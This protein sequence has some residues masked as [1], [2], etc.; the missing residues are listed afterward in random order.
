MSITLSIATMNWALRQR[1]S[2]AHQQILL[3]VIAD[4]ADPNGITRHCDPAYLEEHSRMT[5]ATMFRR[6]GEL[7]ELGLLQR[8][9]FYSERGAPIYEIRL[10]LDAV[11]DIPIKRRKNP[12]D[13][14]HD[15]DQDTAPESH[16]ETLGQSQ[17]ETLPPT[18]VSPSAAPESQYCDSISP[19]VSKNL[20][21]PPPGALL[22]KGETEQSEK[23]TALWDRFAQSY[24]GIA[25]MDQQA[26]KAELDELSLDDA[27]WAVSVLPALKD[28]L[29]KAKDRPPKNAHIWLRKAMFRNFPR[30]RIEA[31][32]PD[33]VWISDGSVGD[34]ALR[35]VRRLAKQP[36]PF[37]KTRADGERGYS[38]KAAIGEDLLAMLI[39]ADQTPVGWRRLDRGTAPFAAWQ[40]RFTDWIGAPIAT[41]PGTQQIRA[42]TLW[43][44]KKDGTIYQD[45]DQSPDTSEDTA[46]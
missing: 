10:T 44:P 26:A 19:P 16:V 12:D 11:V 32:P 37:V 39:F 22:S 29:R 23:R 3:Y 25:T 5:R 27:E 40:Q 46:A 31:P 14:T 2:S 8:F 21:Q 6:L 36:T 17:P 45:E 7:E 9:K 18:K 28:E 42:P 24:P 33:Q 38:H 34:R 30:A 1:L 15:D 41:E 4:S 13:D 20:P 35:F 43:P